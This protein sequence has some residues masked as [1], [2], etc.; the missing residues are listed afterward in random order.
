MWWCCGKSTKDAA[1]CKFSKHEMIKD[2]E[3]AFFLRLD[4]KQESQLRCRCCKELGHT[5]EN[6]PLDPNFKTK[7]NI[8]NEVDRVARAQLMKK[9]FSDT[10]VHTAHM[11]K[12]CVIMNKNELG[13]ETVVNTSFKRG[14]MLFEDFNYANY[15]SHI[16]VEEKEYDSDHEK[17][18]RLDNQAVKALILPDYQ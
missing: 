13:R 12:K 15:N 11:L 16:L 14:A 1:G 6:C 17:A 4:E 9:V 18:K 2:E 3:D 8:E 7:H 5:I 10:H